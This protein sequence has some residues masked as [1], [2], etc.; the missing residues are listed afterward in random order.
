MS[1]TE[2]SFP[3]PSEMSP[4][5]AYTLD[6][7]NGFQKYANMSFSGFLDRFNFAGSG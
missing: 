3:V 6:G 5:P 7:S 4:E 1:I 2:E